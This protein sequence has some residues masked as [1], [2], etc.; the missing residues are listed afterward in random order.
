M[1]AAIAFVADIIVDLIPY[2][3]T[4]LG[5]A[6]IY[7]AVSVAATIGL[8]A[9][10]QALAG[11]K[12]SAGI[13]SRDVTVRGTISPRQIIYGEARTG[14]VLIY[15][16]LGGP[17][18]AFLFFVIAL[19]GHQ[20]DTI[21]DVWLDG[22]VVKSSEI[23][24]STGV[25]ATTASNGSFYDGA[26][27]TLSIYKH[28]GTSA[29]ASDATMN[30]YIPEWDS[31]HRGA[32][33]AYI[34]LNMSHSEHCYPDGA[35]SNIFALV[36]GR[37]LYDPRL[38]STNGGSGSHRVNDATSWTWSGNW[39]LAV[40]DYLAGGSIYYDVATP[41]PM[42][43]IAE[44]NARIDDSFT[45][46]AANHADEVI[47]VPAP[48]L[49]G[50]TNWTNASA[51]VVGTGT[52]FTYQLAVGNMLLG[53]DGLWYTVLSI[54]DDTHLSLTANFAGTTT[55]SGQTTQW[56]TTASATTTQARYTA[57]GQL[58]CGDTHATNITA[59]LSAGIGH[60]TYAKGKYRIYAGVYD[61]PVISLGPDDLTGSV[62]V[63]TH[64]TGEDL[65]NLVSGTF[66]DEIRGWQQ[67]TFP[68]QQSAAY[69]ADDGGV[70]PRNVDLPMTRTS[71]RCQRIANVLLQQSR[72]KTAVTLSGCGP[73]AMNI[74]TWE[75]FNL[76]IPEYSWVNQVLRCLTW[77]LLASGYVEITARIEASGA[78]ADLP[79]NQYQILAGNSA[80]TISMKLPDPPTG[81]SAQ[82]VY[83]AMLFVVT[84]PTNF[85]AG[86]VIELWES[87]SATPFSGAMKVGDFQSSVITYSKVDA[88]PRF[89]WVRVRDRWGNVSTT[90]PASNGLQAVA[91]MPGYTLKAIANCNAFATQAIATGA[92][93]AWS[94]HV[95][96]SN[97]SYAGGVFC[98]F[99]MNPATDNVACG[100]S[101]A[102]ASGASAFSLFTAGWGVGAG[103]GAAPIFNGNVLTAGAAPSIADEFT[104]FFDGFW[105]QWLRNGVLVHQEYQPDNV[106]P[107][108]LFGD[109]HEPGAQIANIA[110]GPVTQSS[111]NPFR[112]TGNAVTHDSTAAKVGGSAAFDSTV[113][114]INGYIT[115]HVQGKPIFPSK[116]LIIGLAT[117]T[118][119]SVANI[120]AT[121]LIAI[122]LDAAAG[123]YKVITAG[124]TAATIGGTPAAT[125]LLVVDFDGS[126]A[127]CTING[128]LLDTRAI[129]PSAQPLFGFIA[130]KDAGGALSFLS[131]GPGTT[132]D[133]VPTASID[134]NA[135][136][137][138]YVSLVAGPVNVYDG[139]GT[140]STQVTSVSVPAYPQ[141]INIIVTATGGADETAAAGTQGS[142]C[143]A[144]LNSSSTASIMS[145]PN[146]VARNA[147][148][149]DPEA[150]NSF[151]LER[152]FS[153]AAN[154]PVTYYL[155]AQGMGFSAAGS[156][157][158]IANVMLKAEVLKR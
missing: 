55:T 115:A 42:L 74:V 129:F 116:S 3:V 50:T 150:T 144:I 138:V 123:N 107:F 139:T 44:S 36:R 124:T 126:N 147:S 23:N 57:D 14:G 28:T 22:R 91:A 6:V 104:T 48:V 69:Q 12:G 102:P 71:W 135:A 77:K 54:T 26:T 20:C 34:V 142:T 41:N 137:D 63:A 15:Y 13:A 87:N 51:A 18:G 86:S 125:D 52:Q 58:S 127:H 131:F 39:A 156:V 21:E 152:Q 10:A 121:P 45:I 79:T 95:C 53:P 98:T 65:Y 88:I 101:S 46:T 97:Q 114:S 133:T 92:T 67:S 132:P 8:S 68:A 120:F 85:G 141:A 149:G 25:V 49:S 94:T 32:G 146:T 5:Y 110:F 89:Y 122:E 148:T 37:R 153:V 155:N 99:T 62:E 83:G 128:Q 140:H 154:T 145:V 100:L 17:N 151:A 119:P 43:T 72:N 59:L 70:F 7:T 82:T 27:A 47:T 84:M 117:I 1:P 112:A 136:T 29:Q 118:N 64:P 143:A 11:K 113:V 9:A 40:R 56:N 111:P 38:D 31:T 157:C 108:F 96:Q 109:M 19:A 30:T 105:W 130:F 93:T 75:T 16:G 106:T 35:P 61:A 103:L 90:F 76:T 33:I 80:P 81:L 24:P 4:E 66:Y 134:P 158:N 60:L 73:A 78:Y 2:G